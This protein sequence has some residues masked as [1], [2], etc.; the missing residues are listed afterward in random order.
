MSVSREYHGRNSA[1]SN[2][3]PP[4]GAIRSLALGRV[5]S[6]VRVWTVDSMRRL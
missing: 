6:T 5:R 1:T 2:S 4:A 3:P